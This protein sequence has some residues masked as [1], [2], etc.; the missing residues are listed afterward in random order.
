[1]QALCNTRSDFLYGKDCRCGLDQLTCYLVFQ[2][3]SEVSPLEIEE[4]IE[5]WRSA[6]DDALRTYVK[7]HYPHGVISVL[8]FELMDKLILNILN[9][10]CLQLVS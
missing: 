8:L 7:D 10:I 1:M 2:E 9:L 5:S 3:A 6:V 4:N